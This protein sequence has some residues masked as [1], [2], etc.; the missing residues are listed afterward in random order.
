VKN[1]PI[2]MTWSKN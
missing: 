2:F 1:H